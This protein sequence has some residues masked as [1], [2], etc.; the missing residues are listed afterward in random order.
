MAGGKGALSSFS[1]LSRFSRILSPGRRPA[2]GLFVSLAFASDV[3]LSYPFLSVPLAP[4]AG[5]AAHSSLPCPPVESVMAIPHE[6][7]RWLTSIELLSVL[8]H[9]LTER[10]RRSKERE[11]IWRWRWRWRWREW[12]E[13]DFVILYEQEGKAALFLVNGLCDYY[14]HHTCIYPNG[15]QS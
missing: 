6:D 15:L 12:K 11:E 8:C 3:G 5:S 4:V 7:Q 14:W 2:A 13:G 1:S 9:H 10:R